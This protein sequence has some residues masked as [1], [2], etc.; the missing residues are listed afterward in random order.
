MKYLKSVYAGICIGLGGI[1]YLSV[2]NKVLGA[3]LFSIGL[4]AV[5]TFGFDLYTGKVCY[6]SWYKKPLALLSV[7][8][9]NL[10]GALFMAVLASDKVREAAAVLAEAKLAK[11]GLRVFLDAVLCGI[12][13]AIAVRGF[14]KAEGFGRYLIA[15][16]GVMVF[17]LA[18]A[19][20]VVANMFYFAAGGAF[21]WKALLY[22]LIYTVGNTIGGLLLSEKDL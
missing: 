3:F 13:I 6:L 21:T 14:K 9:G 11:G 10:L 15:V 1:V 16:L 18:G 19:E 7:W 12:C 5:L 17:I 8:C 2:E 20:H 4:C 22:I